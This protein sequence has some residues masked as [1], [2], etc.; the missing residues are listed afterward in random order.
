VTPQPDEIRLTIPSEREFHGV[1]ELVLTGLASRRNATFEGLED[2]RIA[3][4]SLLAR[5]EAGDQ[6]TLTL[7]VADREIRTSVGPFRDALRD[8]L[9]QESASGDVGLRRILDAVA[10]SVE[11]S[12][13]VDGHW[14]ELTKTIRAGEPS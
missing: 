13:R 9:V 1:A 4:D 14:V 8:E 3:L 7:R 10:D 12:E 2:L 6:V 11:V 5:R